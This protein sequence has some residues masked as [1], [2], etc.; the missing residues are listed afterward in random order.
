MEDKHIVRREDG[1][2]DGEKE[3]GVGGAGCNYLQKFDIPSK[4]T[5]PSDMAN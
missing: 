3:K 1:G 5:E 2:M 4:S